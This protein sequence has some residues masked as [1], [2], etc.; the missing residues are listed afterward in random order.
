M[1]PLLGRHGGRLVQ[2]HEVLPGVSRSGPPRPP[3][4]RPDGL[5]VEGAHRERLRG[6]ARGHTAAVT[7][8]PTAAAAARAARSYR[9]AG[10][11]LPDVFRH[12]VLQLLDDYRSV[13]QASGP[14]AGAAV[15]QDAP[16]PTG[17][18]RVDAA[19]AG[20]AEHLSR[21][22][23]WEAADWVYDPE[24]RAEH[25]WWVPELPGL[26]VVALR[27]SPLAFRRR[28]VLLDPR[29]LERA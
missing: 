7:F 17:D 20:L 22:D 9:A 10:R 16:V 6:D 11:A 24:R 25:F 1:L 18:D 23:G 3:R 5:R 29:S 15:F 27:D 14:A 2:V 8:A 4:P 12:V 21:Q 26:Q 28:G 19:L 13:V